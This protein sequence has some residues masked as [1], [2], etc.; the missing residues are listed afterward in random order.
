MVK[1][2]PLPLDRVVDAVTGTVALSKLGSGEK[3]EVTQLGEP[4]ETGAGGVAFVISEAFVR[5]AAQTQASLLVVSATLVDRV[6]AQL[7]GAVRVVVSS[8]DAYVGL[9]KLSKV[10]A[11]ADPLGDWRAPTSGRAEI[12][13]T[14]VV[15]PGAVVCEGARVGARTVVL[16]NAVIGPGATIGTDCVIFPGAVLYPKTQLGNRVRIHANSVLGSDGFGY[17]RGPQGS[18]KIWHL[19]RV[20]VEDDVEIG[21]GAMVD[22]GTLK[23]TLIERGAKIDN[24]CQIGHNGHVKAHAILC[25]Q[26]GMAGNVTVGKGAILAGKVGVADKLDIGDGAL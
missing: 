6:L 25:A 11:D 9:A 5:D 1:I 3:L 8:P 2:N 21:A 13:A 4:L 15:A 12:D 17:A 20:V 19:G 23:D 16:A 24:L 10:I 26:V 14:A 18:V 7:P 22:R